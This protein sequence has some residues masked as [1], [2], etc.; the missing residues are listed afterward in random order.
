MPNLVNTDSAEN[1]FYNYAT[2][3]V[4]GE[5]LSVSTSGFLDTLF[6]TKLGSKGTD[7]NS[8]GTGY[9]IRFPAPGLEMKT[10]AVTAGSNATANSRVGFDTRRI[11]SN[12]NSNNST[13]LNIVGNTSTL[14][15]PVSSSNTTFA[16]VNDF[17]FVYASFTD[18]TL[19]TLLKFMYLGWLREPV[20][21]GTTLGVLGV[22]CISLGIDNFS[23]P[24]STVVRPTSAN[25]TTA[26]TLA[27]AADTITSPPIVCT[28]G[29]DPG[30]GSATWTDITIRDATA[31]NNPVGNLWNCI[32][33]PAEYVVGNLYKNT[34]AYDADSSTSSQ[35]VYLCVMPWGTRKLGMRIYTENV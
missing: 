28:P 1:V 32:E 11:Q 15:I 27:T 16:V 19:S 34:G 7:W 10:G 13:G 30:D 3:V 22:C 17:A 6:S 31:P 8:S 4:K 5:S 29:T 18:G 23:A 2:P 24:F 9:T 33:M 14:G 25:S 26:T 12:V 21:T 20:Y 35:D